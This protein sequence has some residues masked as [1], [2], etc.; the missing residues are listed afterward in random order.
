MGAAHLRKRLAKRWSPDRAMAAELIGEV[1]AEGAR[2][3]LLKMLRNP[4]EPARGLGRLGGEGLFEA[5]DAVLG[6]ASL[7]EDFRLDVLE[8]LCLLRTPQAHAR[9]REALAGLES[10]EERAELN[11]WLEE[12]SREM[13]EAPR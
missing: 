1:R 10:A 6:E 3:L 8:G 4:K 12:C 9:V 7:Q 11:A 2:E 13:E 5:L